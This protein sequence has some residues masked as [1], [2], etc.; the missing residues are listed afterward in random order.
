MVRAIH[1]AN[2]Q[3]SWKTWMQTAVIMEKHEAWNW[4]SMRYDTHNL[5]FK[6]VKMNEWGYDPYVSFFLN[7]FQCSN[8]GLKSSA[9]YKL[10]VNNF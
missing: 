1:S 10:K 7:N 5:F 2:A 4:S 9:L 8:W 6:G 3:H